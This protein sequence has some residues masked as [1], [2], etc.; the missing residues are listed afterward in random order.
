MKKLLIRVLAFTSVS[1]FA[2]TTEISRVAERN[3]NR[4]LIYSQNETTLIFS[5]KQNGIEREIKRLDFQVNGK[6]LTISGDS[7]RYQFDFL[8]KMTL[9]S[10]KA[11]KWCWTR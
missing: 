4:E 10:G 3:S 1:S 6:E 5:L 8:K 11:Y 9:V 7:D 2:A